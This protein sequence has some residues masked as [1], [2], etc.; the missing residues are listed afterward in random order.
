[1]INNYNSLRI[2]LGTILKS[3][4]P[5]GIGQSPN[6]TS[7]GTRWWS[8]TTFLCTMLLLF[9]FVS[10]GY[11]NPSNDTKGNDTKKTNT[12]V[13]TAV[14]TCAGATVLDPVTLPIAG[15]ALVCGGTN[16]IN[17]G[18]ATACGS[19]LYMGGQEALYS[20]TPTTSGNYNIAI[21]GQTWTGIFVFQG[22]PTSGGTC[23][24]NVTSSTS[25]KNV[26]VTLTAGLEYF[27]MFDT[28]PSPDSPCPGTFSITPPPPACTGTP[29]AGTVAPA[30]QNVC[31]G[32]AVSTL[33]A[34]GLS[35]GVSGLTYKWQLTTADPSVPANW[36]DISPAQTNTTYSP[37]VYGGTTVY[38]RLVTTC[39]TSGLSA[40]TAYATI[41]SPNNPA[42]QVSNAVASSISNSGF[43]LGWTNGNGAR[44]VVILS[45]TAITDPVNGSAAALV[46][47]SA[48]A[49][50]GQQIMYDGTGTSV[51]I[52]GLTCGTSYNVKVYEYLRCGAGP[53]DYY[54]N[55]SSGTNAISVSTT[56]P[57]SASLPANNNF[58]GFTG[59]NLS[60]VFPGWY[61]ALGTVQN[62]NPAGT[63]SAWTS[64]TGLG[65]TTARINLYT[66]TR[67]EW[68]ISPKVNLTGN[69][70]IA[71]KA[72][73]TTWNGTSA[74]TMGSDDAVKVLISTDGCGAVWTVLSTMNA[75]N[76]L[77]NT[78]QDFVL[79]LTAYTGQTVQL[80]F[81]A[82]DGP[83]DNAEDYD[84][85][86]GAI[87]I[88]LIPSCNAPSGLTATLTST[89]SANFSWSVP[90]PTPTQYEWAATT[91]ATPP[92]S[93]DVVTSASASSL[94]LAANT[95]YYL[96]VRS[97]CGVAEY[98]AWATSAPFYTGYCNPAPSSVDGSGITNI[99]FGVSPNVVNNTTATE[100]GN[101]GDYS[102]QI[103][104]LRRNVVSTVNVTY[105]TGYTYGTTIWVD[106]NNDLD[107][108][109][110]G[111]QVAQG[112]S[113][114]TNPTTLTLSF[115]IPLST[116]L[117]NYRMRIG[118]TDAEPLTDPCYSSTYGSFEDYTLNVLSEP[119][120]FVPTAIIASGITATGATLNWTAPT[121]APSVGY[122]YEVRTSGAAGSGAT[123]LFLASTTAS[124]GFVIASGLS[125]NTTY[126]VY[127]Q[128][129]CGLGDLSDWTS[130][131][132][133]ST[134]CDAVT[135]FPWN[136]GFETSTVNCLRVIDGNADAVTWGLYA[137][138][139]RTGTNCAGINTDFN[140]DNN[141]YLITPQ[142]VLGTTPKR[143]T[144]WVKANS[145]SE[146]NE[147]S[148]RVSTTGT[149]LGDFSTV[150]L[151]STPVGSTTYSQL[152]A[153]LSAFA[154]QTIY[155]AFVRDA[156]PADGWVL[157]VDDVVVEN[158]PPI[159]ASFAPT[160]VCESGDTVTI[161]GSGFIGVTDVLVGS[162][163]ATFSV[164]DPTTITF[165]VPVGATSD[166]LTVITPGG[167]AY[168]AANLT[169]NQFPTNN[170]ITGPDTKVCTNGTLQLVPGGAGN[171][172][173]SSNDLIATVDG[174]GL[175]TGV[176]SG[177]VTISFSI[178]DFGC[179]TTQ[180]YD[181]DVLEGV[182]I[183]TQ[184]P[185]SQ[186]IQTGTD[187]S[188]SVVATGDGLT[189]QW[190]TYDVDTDSYI[191]VVADATFSDV[192]TATLV[193]TNTPDTL[194]GAEF[195]C[196]VFGAAPCGSEISGSTV[197]SVGS[198]AIT[199][200]PSNQT[201]C[202]SGS[203]MFTV[204]TSG[205]VNPGGYTWY[206]DSGLGFEPVSTS[207][208][209]LTYSGDGTATLTVSGITAAN[210]G[211]AY[212]VQVDGPA[213]TVYSSVA[214]LTVNSTPAI[215]LQAADAVNCSAGGS[216]T[217]TIESSGTV[218]TF[219]WQYAT[220]AS[221]PWSPVANGTP[222]AAT[223]TATA[224]SLVVA[225]TSST[226]VSTYY[227][228]VVLNGVGSCPS[229]TS[230]VASLTINNPTVSN[231][232]AATVLRGNT[233]TFT[234]TVVATAPVYQ[235]EYSTTLGG[236]YA[237]VADA[238][239]VGIT[240]TGANTAS[241]NVI[242]SAGA[243]LGGGR[244]YRLKVT[245]GTCVV[246]SVGALLTLTDY[247]VP[248]PS[249][250]DANGIT[251]VTIGSINNTTGSEV[252]N[253]GNYTNLST[254][255]NEGGTVPFSIT[256]QTGY[257][258]GTKIWIDFNKDGDFV[259]AG[260]QVY[261]GLSASANPTTLSGSFAMPIGIPSGITRMR[262]GG[263]DTDSGP[264]T[265]CYT[266]SYGS[267]ED[268]TVNII[269]APSCAGSPVA[270]TGTTSSTGVCSG[271]TVN[272]GL[273]GVP[274][275][276]GLTYQWYSRELPAGTFAPIGG[277]NL[278]TYTT[279]A[280]TV[281]S[282][283]YNL[284]T[285]TNSGLS[286]PS[287]TVA[288]TVNNCDYTVTRNTGITYNS[289]MSTGTTYTSFTG[290]ADDS[291][292]NVVSLAGSTFKYNGAVVTG[293]YATSNGWMTFNTAQTSAAYTNDLTATG[294]NNVLAPF[295]DDLVLQGNNLANKDNSMKYKVDGVLGSGSAVITVEWA[296]MERLSF[297]DP[298]MNFQVVLREVDNS[299]EFNYG[300]MQLFNGN[301][302][303]ATFTYSVGMN[304]TSPSTATTPNRLIQQFTDSANFGTASQT[305]LRL[306]P[307][308]N[309]QIRFVPAA[310]YSGGTAPSTVPANDNPASAFVIGVS[311]DP[312]TT[313]CGNVYNSKNATATPAITACSAV[314]PGNADDDVW[315]SFTADAT[316]SAH[317]IAVQ[318]SPGYNAVV[319]ILDSA[320]TPVA[321]QNAV[322]NGLSEVIASVTLVSGNQYYA[323]VYD[324]NTGAAGGSGG[325]GEFTICVNTVLPPP[326]YDEPA[327]AISLT[328][329]SNACTPTA[330]I[331][332]EVLRATATAGVTTCTG[333]PDDDVW[334]KFTTGPVT[335]GINHTISV[336]GV[337]TF[338]AA[339]QVYNG[340]P[341]LAN[342]L[343][344]VNNT[345]NGGLESYSSSALLPDTDYY[346]RIF[347]TG[348]GAANGNF[349]VCVLATAPSCIA[350][351][352]APSNG[353]NA[354][355]SASGT[356]LTWAAAPSATAY[357][358]YF[359]S[360]LVSAD[361]TELTWVTPVLTP[362][363]YSWSVVPKN[364]FGT[365]SG[366][367][368]FTF[369]VN[370]NVTYYLDTD[371]DG[372]GNNLVPQVSCTGAPVGYVAVGGDC[373][374]LIASINPGA[375]EICYDGIDQNCD[376]NLMN[377]CSVIT[378]TLRAED[379]GASLAT[380]SQVVRGNSF[381]QS[382]P[383]GVTVTGYRFK[384]TNLLTSEER[385]VERANYI[386]QLTY[387]DF[388]DYNTPYSVEVA[389][390]LNQ[391]W[392]ETYGAPCTITTPGVPNTVLAATSCGAT[393]A[394]MNSIIRAVVVPSA[395]SY[396]FEVSLI[397]GAVAVETTT[398]VKT[399]E[400]LNL[401]QLTG[402]SI[403]YGAEY[404]VRVKVQVPTS[405]GPQWST[406]YGTAC[407]V[408]TPLAPEASIEGCGAET[409]IAPAAMTTTIYASPVG[410]A[411]QYKFTLTDGMAYT[412]TYT[413]PSRYFKLSNFNAL[414]ALTPGGTYSVTVE[415][416]IYGFYYPGKDCNILVPGGAP[417]VP[418]TRADVDSNNSMGE[419]KAVAYPNPY[420]ESFALNLIS[421]STSPVSIAIYDMAGRLL[422]TREFKFEKL[423]S[424]K[425]GERYPS[426]V[427]SIIVNQDEETQ[428]I[429]VVKK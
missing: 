94:T 14:T 211:Y 396:E 140:A 62:L 42:T 338:N 351:P 239:P 228:Q 292:T 270:T 97:E 80:A 15:Q 23:I 401:L 241:L 271:S 313:V 120:C 163:A 88:E 285:C 49:G 251:N 61:E 160:S 243:A 60:T 90:T 141:D 276:L 213:N 31:L 257:T 103:G 346:I 427:Y 117:G 306:S 170:P 9:S 240:Y 209:G 362:G 176:A 17:S 231:P 321:C 318:A 200:Q 11:N 312:C 341:G 28:Y 29:L 381:S 203:A 349:T 57:A 179:T 206:E 143:L 102:A 8:K 26:N 273:T 301:T 296:E 135:V 220:S 300:T 33:T 407:S 230:D 87:K 347:H 32:G 261:L 367:N 142:L 416:Q 126:S 323:R 41:A 51:A 181:V 134:L 36:S 44:R 155:L 361:Q 258:Y 59:A 37:P 99:S 13:S 25:S 39:T 128:S 295:W 223:Y 46:A 152:T 147:V 281:S 63:T 93:G 146:P 207:T 297:G 64:S 194:D 365:A 249:S 118:G 263:T 364:P 69:S 201:V 358:V 190:F 389:L 19:G 291:R 380:L 157:Y 113:L 354:C 180:T 246:N 399:G 315:F 139:A 244:Y 198:T 183:T 165:V 7:E 196:E 116:P 24:G 150:A 221:G 266:G 229:A 307:A 1:M 169:I 89:T 337:S 247:C 232:A 85:H 106:F 111:E 278:A 131:Y 236:T 98:S 130:A 3:R 144:F 27:I 184:P 279:P 75:S 4:E 124:T 242:S 108:N 79:D 272:L 395:I 332:S 202:D 224:T 161:T 95:T 408:F 92:A 82:T 425:L 428:T 316:Y 379:C 384:V 423:A 252:G 391:E 156:E 22:C 375:T 233:A 175:V 193:I 331:P 326:A 218:G 317:R 369:T 289:V 216:S 53:Y 222:T 109:D 136:E 149:N 173:I 314:T 324:S 158:T 185:L 195:Y 30:V 50:S 304:G 275:E 350:S 303:G 335:T 174:N 164:V 259:D 104:S 77:P 377:S 392:M 86:I 154:G 129:D 197:L 171:D 352:S 48:Y 374:D 294:Q 192:D 268:Y 20:L 359:E 10:F 403:K 373:N 100:A 52:T 329:G 12:T 387:T 406:E 319:Q 138:N 133:F 421:N 262:I 34:S 320:F 368:T 322:G 187:S 286:T 78:L 290:T 153:D 6:V 277:A 101:Y 107:F 168:S 253:Y 397:E 336:Q 255:L 55:V 378:S 360:M 214:S 299:I 96:H 309:S 398:L 344:C 66:T 250:V 284:V 356:T 390:R 56:A 132:T 68:I 65:Q 402:I 400:S 67:N 151:A 404:S 227:Y 383:S 274:A 415:V 71:Y 40:P 91:S 122:N 186:S 21:A 237:P 172:W 105:Q 226:P 235:W 73:V 123:G 280:L 162:T 188:I 366:C 191:A 115:T 265:P 72:A 327:N 264:S 345:G 166:L 372:Y 293:F 385:I 38:Y 2:R 210:N 282:E 376:G 54:Y 110:V 409:G 119:T 5:D 424:Q 238:T 159:I 328:V 112:T 412:Q 353:G 410:G 83:V 148:V 405:S 422:E 420:G 288:V 355:E 215:T 393:L 333:T 357:D 371:G 298:N 386:F 308:C 342:S 370:A 334:Y 16:D 177:T 74:A 182:T 287:S 256:Y 121:P 45:P 43:S 411:T 84:F 388:A 208:S 225:T 127:V 260:E 348:A 382:I 269:A 305:N 167:T 325:S 58:A 145:A 125:G 426:G 35:T 81:Q 302:N 137:S 343:A 205:D 18:N 339:L 76:A 413:T 189:Y 429:R 47:A 234:S 254:N 199:S 245:S 330:S 419:F 311:S 283:F 340:V 267:F 417:I 178:T 418:F 363:T 217:F 204:A 310:A 114:N 394:Q 248:A 414:Q 70:R 212:F 219:E